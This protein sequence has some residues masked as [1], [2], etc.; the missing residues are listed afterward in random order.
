MS[1]RPSK[2]VRSRINVLRAALASLAALSAGSAVGCGPEVPTGDTSASTGALTAPASFLVSFTGGTIPANADGLI[3]AAGGIAVARYRS[4]GAMLARSSAPGFA[5]AL[6]ATAGVDAVGAVA[7]VQSRLVPR[8]APGPFRRSVPPSPTPRPHKPTGDPLSFRQWDMDQIHAPAAHAISNGKSSVLVGVLD[9]GI[10]V[11]HP[12]LVG[13]VDASR[14]ASCVGGVANVQTA[15]WANDVIGHGTHVSGTIAGLKNG[16]GIVGVAPGVRLA[17]VKVVIDDIN[18]PSFGLV[19][20]DAFVCA[21]DWSIAHGFDLMNASLAIDPFTAPID[22][23]FC[24]DEPDREAIVKIVRRAVLAAGRKDISLVA[25]TNNA[26]TDLSTLKGTTAGS[27]CRFLPVQ[28]PSVIGVSAVGFNRKLSF[29]SN[30]GFGAVDLTAPGGDSLVRD[31]LVTDTA[32][33][34]QILSSIPPDSLFYAGAA[35]YDGQVQDCSSGACATYAY[36]QGTSQATPHVTGVAA[37][38]LSRFGKLSPEALL[39]KLRMGANGLPCPPSPYD[40]GATGQPATCT[41]PIS[42]NNFYGAGEVDALP[43]VQ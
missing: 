1:A 22:D 7:A 19:L 35:D 20:P 12:D 33:S 30:Y 5:T 15:A 42:Y 32:A 26:F 16:I 24:T 31:P 14:S 10:D 38:V 29:Y 3:A 41:G 37:L 11:T 43:A 36:L 17:A 6:R 13:Q 18:D 23:L 28:L 27:T 40:P 8:P 25:A 34:G 4:F 2:S 39:V 21:I 9:S